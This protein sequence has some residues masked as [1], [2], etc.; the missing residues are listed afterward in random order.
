MRRLFMVTGA[1]GTLVGRSS[2][3]LLQAVPPSPGTLLSWK[4]SVVGSGRRC[5]YFC[6]DR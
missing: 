1:A 3:T 5:Q 2:G 6:V 4:V